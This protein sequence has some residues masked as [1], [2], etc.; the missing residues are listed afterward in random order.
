[1]P[2][3]DQRLSEIYDRTSGYCHLCG[4]KLAFT[5][6]NK[7][8]QKGAWEVDHSNPKAKGGTDRL[9]NLY[10]ACVSCNRDKSSSNTRT[11]R[12][13]YGQNRAPLSR[14]KRK[15][16][17]IQNALVAGVLGGVVGGLAGPVWML[18]GAA[19]G[20]RCGY[21]ANPNTWWE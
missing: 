17:R 11:A 18:I 1:M 9:N 2:Y 8:G 6:Y 5:N 12:E 20:A 16:V 19:I 10:A 4:K 7:P 13:W 14:Q 3:G 21:R 15:K